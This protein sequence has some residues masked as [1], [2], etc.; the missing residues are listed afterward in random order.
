MTE[1]TK[2]D[3]GKTRVATKRVS[4]L[5]AAP[6]NPRRISEDALAGLSASIARFGLLQPVIWNQQT[7]H[8]VG[9]HQRIKALVSQG[10]E[11]TDVIV[12]DLPEAEEKAANIALNSPAIAGEFVQEDLDALLLEIKANDPLLFDE[13][14]LGELASASLFDAEGQTEEDAVPDVPEQAVSERG[15]VYSLGQHR[16]M[17]GDSTSEADVGRLLGGEEPFLMVTDPPYGVEYD[18]EW[19]DEALADGADRRSGKV[20]SDDRVDWSDAWLL[21]PGAVAYVWHGDRDG[22]AIDVGLSLRNAALHVRGRVVWNKGRFCIGRGH[23]HWQHESAW[24][25]VRKGVSSRW[26]G[27]RSQSTVWD[28]PNIAD[29]GKTNHGTQKPVE[30]MARPIRNHGAPGDAVYDPFLGSGTTVIAAE[31]LG[32][33]CFGM[34][35][36][37]P[38]VDVIRRRWAEFVHGPDCDWQALTPEVER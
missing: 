10:I 12:V 32:R 34:E 24:Y 21:F 28:I 17:C 27:D 7:G 1:L 15:A 33:R 38:Y 31:K 22:L 26:C 18:P 9:G 11:E 30:C 29:E 8:V 5:T 37:P 6:Y 19:R 25:A 2:A 16:V 14:R 13:V 35:I 23:Y 4:E 36:D 3:P 20:A